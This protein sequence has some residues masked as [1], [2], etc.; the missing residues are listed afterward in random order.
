VGRHKKL[1]HIFLTDLPIT[2]TLQSPPHLR[3]LARLKIKKNSLIF[4]HKL[5]ASL[6]HKP[7]VNKIGTNTA[8]IQRQSFEKLAF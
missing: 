2:H 6:Y 7:F 3:I 4:N 1:L 5:F 8:S